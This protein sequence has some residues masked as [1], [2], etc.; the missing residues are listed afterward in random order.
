AMLVYSTADFED[1]MEPRPDLTANL[2]KDLKDVVSLLVANK[3]PFRLHAT[4]NESITRFLNVFE[5]VNRETPFTGTTWFFDHCET[6]SDRNIERVKALGGG[7]AIQD[8]IAFQGE[9][10]LDRYGKNAA[11][12]TPPVRRMLEGGVPVGAGTDATRVASHDPW[13]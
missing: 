13:R 8:R 4:Y 7:I 10:F 1:F 2:E 5:E 6:I 12:R 9:Y 3:W 11:E